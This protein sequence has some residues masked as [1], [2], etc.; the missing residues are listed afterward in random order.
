MKISVVGVTGLVGSVML[1]VL[2]ER[3]FGQEELLPAASVRSVGKQLTF[4][5][6]SF[7]VMSVEDA[8][9][10]EPDIAIFSAGS[11]V[12]LQYASLFAQKGTYVIDNS[13]AWRMETH[14]PL[15][16]PEVNADILTPE[17]HIIANPNC[18]TIQM[19]MALAPLHAAYHLKRLVISTYQSVTGT[20]VKAVQQLMSEREGQPADKAYPHPIDLNVLPHGGTFEA[21]GYTTEETKLVNETRKILRAPEIGITATVVRVPVTGGHSEAI[22]AEFERDFTLPEVYQLLDSMPGVIVLDQPDKNEYPMPILSHHKDAVFVGRVREDFS[23]PR[24][25][26]M[27]VVA[28]NLRKGA[29]TNAIQIAEWLIKSK[30]VKS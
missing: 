18:S 28:D 19:V 8:L 16:V 6:R 7:E 22:N 11:T 23:R 30:F 13:S 21:D 4:G 25:L 1:K 24:T 15:V 26:N 5:G 9:A 17:D 27:W 12:S 3:G 20:G 2:E 29:A 14:I 10:R